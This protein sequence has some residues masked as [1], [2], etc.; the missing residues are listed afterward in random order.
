MKSSTHF[1]CSSWRDT[2]SAYKVRIY[3]VTLTSRPGLDAE[4][5]GASFAEN[6][7][8]LKRRRTPLFKIDRARSAVRGVFAEEKLRNR[9]IW[10]SLLFL[11]S[12]SI[13]PPTHTPQRFLATMLTLMLCRAAPFVGWSAVHSCEGSGLLR[14]TGWW[15]TDGFDRRHTTRA[16]GRRE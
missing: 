3:T 7:Y 12:S 16:S 15:V 14:R 5:P 10:R 4:E 2:I 6:F 8:G 1:S 11:V 13:Y 9:E